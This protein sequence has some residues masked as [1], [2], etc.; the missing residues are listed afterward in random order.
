MKTIYLNHDYSTLVDDEDFNSLN[1]WKWI[2]KESR[3]G[4][5]YAVRHET[6]NGKCKAIKMHRVIMNTP[7]NLQCDH[8]FHNT[9]DNRKFI[10]VDGELKVNLRN[11][12][13]A[14]NQ[15]NGTKR[16]NR[17]YKG[18]YYTAHWKSIVAKICINKKL[19]HLGTFATEKEAA[20]AYNIAATKYFGE[21]ANLNII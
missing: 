13:N 9:L 17:K 6:I 11:C 12:T 7:S 14:Q 19:I 18:V 5:I 4:N 8:V 3:G 1:Q 20:I 2:A 10:E 21:F 15:M 16:I